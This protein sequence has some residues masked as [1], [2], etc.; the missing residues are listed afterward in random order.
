MNS[1]IK[2]DMR[3]EQYF[4]DFLKKH[5][6]SEDDLRKEVNEFY[7]MSFSTSRNIKTKILKNDILCFL[8]KPLEYISDNIIVTSSLKNC[9]NDL[10]DGQFVIADKLAFE[11]LQSAYS[12]C[13]KPNKVEF[14]D[15]FHDGQDLKYIIDKITNALPNKIVAIGGGR[16]MDYAKFISLQT[17]IE[18]LAIPSSLATHVY[19]SPKIHALEPIK[20]LGYN[21]TIDG[22]PAHLSL[23]DIKL[24][25]LLLSENKRLIYSGFGDIMA[26]IN[27]RHD[28]IDSA[29]NGNER[30]SIFVDNSIE[31]IINYLKDIDVNKPLKNWISDYVFIQCL[32]CHIT[33]WVGSA[34]ASGAEHLF[35]KSV[36]D[37]AETSPIHGEVVA[38]GVL[39]FSYIRNKDMQ[40]VEVLMDKFDISR[41]LNK[42][43][44]NKDLVIL[45]LS[46]S[47]DEGHK[48]NRH[49]ILFNINTSYEYF[50]DVISKMLN[51]NVLL[52]S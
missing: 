21:K 38:L 17:N 31:L 18:L 7:E 39:I 24:L 51:S 14:I 9:L 35:A 13:L 23:V 2:I 19:A 48:K 52:E 22:D 34:P 32:L 37:N 30:Y 26:F 11:F 40:L 5:S 27:A 6:N 36:E 4:F 10:I 33:D 47:A 15:D 43:G 41:S 42:L 28:W 44:L 46:K 45:A 16:T 25:D 8:D 1:E 29:Y 49:T 3:L 50:S 12:I 20:D